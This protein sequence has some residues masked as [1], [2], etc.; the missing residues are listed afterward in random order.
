MILS[1]C[2]PLLCCSCLKHALHGVI[3]LDE[4]VF[5]PVSHLQLVPKRGNCTDWSLQR[6]LIYRMCALCGWDRQAICS[7]S[8][9][10]RKWSVSMFS[11]SMHYWW[12][13]C[14]ISLPCTI[15]CV[16]PW[17]ILRILDDFK[18]SIECMSRQWC[19][20]A[21]VFGCSFGRRVMITLR[22]VVIKRSTHLKLRVSH[23]WWTTIC[24]TLYDVSSCLF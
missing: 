14:T 7:S 12:L 17:C 3:A 2:S 5:L 22:G 16:I 15:V 10:L 21:I 6:N 4:Y 20:H 1:W 24:L 23:L 8:H 19:Y 9:A 11:M 18:S 13:L